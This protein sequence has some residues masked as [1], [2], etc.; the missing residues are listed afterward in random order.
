MLKMLIKWQMPC[1]K[2][3]TKMDDG[4]VALICMITGL[5]GAFVCYVTLNGMYVQKLDDCKKI[6]NVYNCEMIFVPVKDVK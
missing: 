1:L 5:F 2:K 4:Y 6:N 3:E